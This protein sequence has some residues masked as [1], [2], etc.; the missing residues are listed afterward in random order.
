[1]G[2]QYTVTLTHCEPKQIQPTPLS[3]VNNPK[4]LNTSASGA[5]SAGTVAVSNSG[6]TASTPNVPPATTSDNSFSVDVSQ[7]T[8]LHFQSVVGATIEVTYDYE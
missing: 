2:K 1:M 4:I 8:T 5:T 6:Q 3:T 7:P